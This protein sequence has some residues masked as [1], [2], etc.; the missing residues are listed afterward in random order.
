MSMIYDVIIFSSK[1]K[2]QNIKCLYDSLVHLQPAYNKVYCIS[3]IKP[4]ILIDGIEYYTDNIVLDV[5]KPKYRPDWIYQQYLKLFQGIS[6]DNYLVIDADIVINNDIEIA[7]NGVFNF[8][9]TNPTINRPFFRWMKEMFGMEKGFDM[10]F[11]SEIMLFNRQYINELIPNKEEF[12][13]KSNS[14]ITQQCFPSEYE[15]YG[16]HIYINHKEKYNYKQIKSSPL[17]LFTKFEGTVE[18]FVLAHKNSKFDTLS[19]Y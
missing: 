8:L 6:V 11:I 2:F 13:N 1:N 5:S 17:F 9:I 12:I 18:E 19:L 15:L 16:N 14:I 10:S 4:P 7:T 3:P